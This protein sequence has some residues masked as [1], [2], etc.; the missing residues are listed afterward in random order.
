MPIRTLAGAALLGAAGL[1][2]GCGVLS[3]DSDEVCASVT[4]EYRRYTA[5]IERASAA[6]EAKW[7]QATERF[8]GRVDA[9]SKKA[10]DPQLK[11][12]LQAQTARLRTAAAGLGEGD[13]TALDAV[14]RDA[15]AKIGAACDG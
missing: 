9:L 6:D 2:S 7:R 3:G 15:P 12:A 8:A 14:L 11:E 1:L 10:D 13:A 4:T 5:E